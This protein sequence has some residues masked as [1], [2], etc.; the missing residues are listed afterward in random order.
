MAVNVGNQFQS[1][2]IESC[3]CALSCLLSVQDVGYSNISQ[4]TSS[5]EEVFFSNKLNAFAYH[6]LIIILRQKV[7]FSRMIFLSKTY[8]RKSTS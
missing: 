6:F 5:P 7:G 4:P 3:V 8:V 1:S 2:C